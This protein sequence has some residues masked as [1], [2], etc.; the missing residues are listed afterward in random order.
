MLSVA[1]IDRSRFLDMAHLPCV[2]GRALARVE[3]GVTSTQLDAA[4]FVKKLQGLIPGRGEHDRNRTTTRPGSALADLG[5]QQLSDLHR[6][7]RRA[8]AHVVARDEEV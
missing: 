4:V 3:R 7:Q 1:T 6:V 8:L 5:R 2:G